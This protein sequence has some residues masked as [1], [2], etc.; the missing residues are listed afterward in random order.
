[1]TLTPMRRA[2]LTEFCARTH[3]CRT[4][5]GMSPTR[6]QI[7]SG[8]HAMQVN[9]PKQ[10]WVVRLGSAVLAGGLFVVLSG[11]AAWAS[12]NC[13]SDRRAT[14]N[15]NGSPKTCGSIGLRG[16]TLVGSTSDLNASD[17]N[18]A[19]TVATN[20][21]TVQP[22]V[23]QEVDLTIT[24]SANVVVDAV[25]VAGGYR[26]NVYRHAGYLPPTLG[27]DQHYIAPLNIYG[28]VPG[29]NYWFTCYHIDPAGALPEV[30][31]AIDIP[32][33][34]AAILVVGVVFERRRR[35]V[36]ATS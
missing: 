36:P 14:P 26:Y 28:S 6:S 2:R 7:Q 16:D 3:D 21:G 15:V 22:G 4:F 12:T 27:A 5:D 8:A 30:P 20:E 23:G 9:S 13:T 32:L 24:G 34:A 10:S 19:G 18:V 25:L 33:A 1:V 17:G 31:Q 29:I 35:K 11:S